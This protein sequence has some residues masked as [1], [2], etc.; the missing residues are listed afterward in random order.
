MFQH[1]HALITIELL[2]D[3]KIFLSDLHGFS[4]LCLVLHVR[5]NLNKVR[6]EIHY[7]GMVVRV[8]LPNHGLST[9]HSLFSLFKF[10][11]LYQDVTLVQ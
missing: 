6:V 5:V 9:E 8:Q 4:L 1:K 7:A 2:R 11:L 10:L 3:F